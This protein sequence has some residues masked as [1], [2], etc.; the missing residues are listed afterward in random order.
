MRTRRSAGGAGGSF[1][2][3]RFA[4]R[5]RSIGVRGQDESRTTGGADRLTGWNAQNAFCS[6]VNVALVPEVGVVLTTV[7]AS[8]QTAPAFTHRVRSLIS[9]TDSLRLGGILR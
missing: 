6:G 9:C 2:S 3:S 8:G 5:K 7:P 4:R 1:F